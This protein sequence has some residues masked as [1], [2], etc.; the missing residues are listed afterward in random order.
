MRFPFKKYVPFFIIFI[1]GILV[2]DCGFFLGGDNFTYLI[3]SQSIVKFGSYTDI[4]L[5]GNPP[6]I[7]F[8]PVYPLILSLFYFFFKE[9]YI[10]PK[11]LNL[12]LLVISLYFFNKILRHQEKKKVPSQIL[13][14]WIAMVIGINPVLLSYSHWILSEIPYL[15]ISLVSL[16]LFYRFCRE[17]RIGCFYGAFGLSIL[18]FYTRPIGISLVGA[19]ILY[20][21]FSKQYREFVLS[22]FTSIVFIIPWFL[23]NILLARSSEIYSQVSLFFVKHPYDPDL[24]NVALSDFVQRILFNGKSY[25][26]WVLG[27]S[28]FD[29]AEN[30]INIFIGIFCLIFIIIGMWKG[31]YL[32]ERFL[33]FYIILYVIILLLWPSAWA[34]K[35]YLILIFP[36]LFVYFYQGMLFTINYLTKKKQSIFSA[37]IP[38]LIIGIIYLLRIFIS[39][40]SKWSKNLDYLKGDVLSPYPPGTAHYFQ[41]ALWA[42]D[43]IPKDAL[44]LTRKSEIFYLYSKHKSISY[45][46]TQ[47]SLE[48]QRFL[49]KNEIQY[50]VFNSS[51]IWDLVYLSPFIM[52]NQG[53]MK[54]IYRT[55]TPEV[56]ILE[57]SQDID[58]S[59]K[60]VNL[61]IVQVSEDA[62]KIAKDKFGSEHPNVAAAMNN[63]AEHYRSQKKYAEAESLY[64]Q[65]LIIWE[66]SYGSEHPYVAAVLSNMALLYKTQK[67]YAEA[68]PLYKRALTIQEK[69]YGPEHPYVATTLGNLAEIYDAQ[70]K[71]GEAELFYI[72]TLSMYEKT[73]GKD[74]IKVA[75]IL[76]KYAVLLRKVEQIK[77]AELIEERAK[78]I[79]LLREND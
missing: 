74:H 58:I 66:K 49:E 71:Y 50:I 23:R 30:N 42:K 21:L 8:P 19:Y 75:N 52:A 34:D 53:R 68:E 35:R 64:K 3:L 17:K 63:L 2:F 5:P 54:I 65:A 10:L 40:P 24:G 39:S 33:F 36:F 70:D 73:F 77:E 28:F 41:A 22:S 16:Y 29:F 61:Q 44:F 18:G 27:A 55:P 72:R 7:L 67:R 76:E 14:P 9:N 56:H 47:D 48:F 43:N 59:K 51:F 31:K 13:L 20:F 69:I 25:G 60:E 32:K 62:V 79:E 45:P 6:H 78:R 38:V 4:H 1:A 57:Y 15:F 12:F 26:S 11:V 37:K 46:L